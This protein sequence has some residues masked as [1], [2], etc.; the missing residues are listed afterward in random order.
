L[1][2]NFTGKTRAFTLISLG[3]VIIFVI[4]GVGVGCGGL[5]A[6]RGGLGVGCAGLGAVR[7]GPWCRLC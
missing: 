2:G 1:P 4:S 7:V 5:C 6:V 3:A